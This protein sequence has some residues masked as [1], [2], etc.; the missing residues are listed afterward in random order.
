MPESTPFALV[1]AGRHGLTITALNARASAAGLQIGATLAD[2]RA[3]L[4]GLA[5]AQAEPRQ[6]DTALT[7]LSHWLGRYGPAH[8]RDGPDGAWVDVTGVAHLFGGEAALIGDLVQR[9][10]NQ[11]ITARAGLADTL[12]AAHAIARFGPGSI[13]ACTA[14]IGETRT[15]L[16][17]LPVAG[18]RLPPATVHLL[19]RLGLKRIGDLY[20]LPRGTLERRFREAAKSRSGKSRGSLASGGTAATVLLR[21]DQ[22]LGLLREPRASLVPTPETSVRLPFPEPLISAQGIET[23]LA[24]LARDL[25][26]RLEALG[27]GGRRFRLA[28]YRTDGTVAGVRAGTSAPARDAA[29]LGRL[30]GAK[31]GGIDAGFGIDLMVL[32]VDELEPIVAA[33]PALDA[34]AASSRGEIGPLIDRLTGRLGADRVLRLGLRPSHRPERAHRFH[35]AITGQAPPAAPHAAAATAPQ[36]T[37]TGKGRDL[38]QHPS[39]GRRLPARPAFLLHPP[40]PVSVVAEVPDGAPVRLRW[41]R[42]VRCIVRMEGPERIAPEWWRGQSATGAAGILGLQGA[43]P[44]AAHLPAGLRP[45]TRDYWRLED[46]TGAGY[47]VFREGLYGREDEG[48][49]GGLGG[50]DGDPRWYL[51]GLFA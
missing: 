21:L 2:A 17:G 39:P 14:G 44:D 9:L 4:P 26:Q 25:C 34:A 15:A 49:L 27:L 24:Q 40:E 11:G 6:D 35:P 10:A 16:A 50:E 18:L 3:A 13:A 41:R 43:S 32:A 45:A 36:R 1:E 48:G 19:G 5:T 37:A 46:G 47:W 31:L 28:L 20:G 29:H 38:G 8:N 7:G 33:Q 51:Q 12:G 30:I 22:A 23:A 42:V